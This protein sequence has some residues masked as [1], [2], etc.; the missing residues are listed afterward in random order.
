MIFQADT[1]NVRVYLL[2]ETFSW[3]YRPNSLQAQ[4]IFQLNV[5]TKVHFSQ[6][7]KLSLP[8]VA[9]P[10][11]YVKKTWGACVISLYT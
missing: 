1:V 10:E 6:K 2:N 8:S 11:S 9:V 5:L 3:K 4:V 7:L